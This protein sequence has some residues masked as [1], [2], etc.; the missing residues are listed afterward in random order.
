[1]DYEFW[2]RTNFVEGTRCDFTIYQD[3]V[4]EVLSLLDVT[5]G[6]VWICSGQSNMHFRMA[7]IFNAQ[8][9][10]DRLE[11]FPNFRLMQVAMMTNDAP[12]DDLMKED[13]V[14]WATTS[15]RSYTSRFSA[16]CLLTASY[17]AEVLGKNK[18]FGLIHSS[19]GGTP[20]ESWFY[21]QH[22]CN[23][24]DYVNEDV[25]QRSNSYLYNAMIHPL[26]R[27]GIKGALWYQGEANI[28][29]NRD[30]Y[31]CAM[32][33][34]I[35]DWKVEFQHY[36]TLADPDH[37]PFGFVQLSTIQQDQ[38][39]GTPMI[40]W[41]QTADYGYVP[42]EV[43]E[44]TFMAVSLDTYDEENGIHPRNKQLPSKRLASAGLNVAY[45]LKDWPTNGPFPETITFNQIDESIQVDVLMDQDFT[46]S[47]AETNGFSYC[48]S[49]DLDACNAQNG[50]W[51]KVDE[52]AVNDRSLSMVIPSCSIGLAYLWETTPVTEMEGLPIYAADQ[53]RLPAAPW[54]REIELK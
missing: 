48:C 32:K 51:M 16:V 14:I 50:Q 3:G 2:F 35:A 52:V 37:M 45:N 8:E 19:W 54:L 4:D 7:G 33:Q 49:N 26:V 23:I 38:N 39:P 29:Y 6:D 25:P 42:N 36:G 24:P 28:R 41:H 5:F 27:S 15:D 40:R 10:L 31:Q 11:E 53:F 1:M 46:Y 44:D 22:L 30:K 18:T 12:Q 20:I 47:D 34:L 21:N 17:M 9:E 43:L 13:F